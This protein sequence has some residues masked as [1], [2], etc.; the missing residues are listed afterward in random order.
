MATHRAAPSWRDRKIGLDTP[1]GAH[2]TGLDNEC[3]VCVRF[4]ASSM[5]LAGFLMLVAGWG[6]VLAA[7]ALLR[8]ASQQS[9]FVLA[10][11]GVQAVG[12]V[13]VVRSHMLPRGRAR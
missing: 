12:L 6:I 10:G 5:K 7:L 2:Y 4:G 3:F 9:T 13:L 8:S 1:R 11:F